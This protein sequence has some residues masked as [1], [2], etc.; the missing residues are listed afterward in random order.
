[1]RKLFSAFGLT[2]ISGALLAGCSPANNGTP[3]AT[4]MSYASPAVTTSGEKGVMVGGS[5][6]VASKDIVD[7]A[8]NS[9]DHTTLVAAV[10]AAGLVETLKGAGPF[11]VFAPTNEAFNKLAK[12]TLE[13]LMKPENKTTLVNILTYHVVSGRYTSNDLKDGMK[14][15]TV[16][17]DELTVKYAS[18]KWSL[19]DA[20]GGKATIST[21]DVIDS[22][23]VTF[24][25]DSVLM[26][27]TDASSTMMK[28]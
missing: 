26:P 3:E 24:V 28:K 9:K 21:I 18:G 17:G 25:V 2:V 11:T 1:M 22:N 23:G 8:L 7:N 6:M 16:Q 10:K 12:G 19:V 14:L 15:K 13:T 5:I 27:K 20:K 4:P